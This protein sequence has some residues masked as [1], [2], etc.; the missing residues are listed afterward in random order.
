MPLQKDH[1]YYDIQKI[2]A[3]IHQN[4]NRSAILDEAAKERWR[5]V[6]INTN[7]AGFN[8]T[9]KQREVAIECGKRSPGNLHFMASFGVDGWGEPGWAEKALEQIKIGWKKGAVAVK[10]WKNVGMELRDKDGNF[11]MADHTDFDPIYEYLK[12]NKIPLATHLGEPKNCWLPLDEMTVTSDK[13]YFTKNPEYHMYLKK[14]FPSYEDQ[15]QARDRVLEKHTELKFIGLHLASLEWSVEEVAKWLDKHPN[16]GVDLAE[17]VCHL[18]HQAVYNHKKVKEFVEAYQDR[19]IY[20]TDQIDDGTLDANEIQETIRGKWHN[21]FRFF[22]DKDTQTAWNVEKQF[23]GLGL[24]KKILRKLFHDNA[25][26]YY[27]RLKK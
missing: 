25:I 17:R 9:D 3:H 27:P 10:I 24:S 23:K 7:Y 21:E 5:L 6:S 12:N 16:A 26:Y 13:E 1:I 8:S 19:I 14:D 20:G 4:V 11:V 2:D 22:S 15:L 18:Q